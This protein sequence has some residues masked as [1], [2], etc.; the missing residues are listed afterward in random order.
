MLNIA[1]IRKEPGTILAYGQFHRAYQSIIDFDFL[2]GKSTPSIVGIV[3]ADKKFEKYFWGNSEIMIPCFPSFTDAK[4]AIHEVSWLL[5]ISSG[6]R[7]LQTTTDFF[8]CYPN[9]VGAHLFAEDIPEKTALDI[10]NKYSRN[11]KLIVGPAGVGFIVPGA[12]KLGVIGGVDWRQIQKIGLQSGGSV[13]VLSA[14]GGMTGELI[15]IAGLSGHGISFA[16]CF[17]GDRFP[18]MTPQELFLVAENDISTTHIVYYGELGGYDE[19]EIADLVKKGKVTKPVIAY[20]AGVVDETFE[21]PIQ[22]GHAKAL[23]SN[24]SEKASEKRKALQSSGIH[25]ASSMTEFSELISRIKKDKIVHT[26][27]DLSKRTSSS[28]SSTISRESL[29]GY[30]FIGTTMQDWAREY[31]IPAQITAAILGRKAKSQLTVDFIELSFLL[32]ADHG[33]QVSGALN[34]II[35]ARAGKSMVESVAAGLLA[36]GPRFGG[37]ITNAA[38]EWFNGVQSNI[39]PLKHVEKY[40]KEKKLIAGIGHKKYR[41]DFPDP[42]TNLLADFSNKLSSHEHYDYAK[43]I[44]QITSKKKGNLIL[45]VDGHIAALM[46]D[47]LKNEE[48]MTQGEISDLISYD[49]FNSL[50]MIPRTIGFVAHYL[51]QKR[52]DEGLFRLPDDQIS[53]L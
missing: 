31:T 20:V 46:L 41:I 53:L 7:A 15:T 14:S 49:F 48:L 37:A 12:L 26:N 45:N 40:A 27:I 21:Q 13:A 17:G 5:N 51:D 52:I 19:Y 43:S 39:N 8:K 38:E 36:I 1:S 33:P 24:N 42:R 47:I 28:F 25:V 16:F 22:F 3:G 10:Y 29:D 44:E 30:E 50:F 34:T 23:A 11:G 18:S 2:S 35:T 32:T 9:A 4:K 6:R